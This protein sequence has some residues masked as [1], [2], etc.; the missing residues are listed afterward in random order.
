[1]KDVSNIEI[2]I[3]K[4]GAICEQETEYSVKKAD[5]KDYLLSVYGTGN[6]FICLKVNGFI[7]VSENIEL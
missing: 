6:Y 4:D 7:I 5:F 3:Y 1:M 2:L